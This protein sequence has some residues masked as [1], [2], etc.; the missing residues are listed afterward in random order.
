VSVKRYCLV[1]GSWDAERSGPLRC[2]DRTHPHLS[3]SDVWDFDR[4]GIVE[5]VRHPT[6]KEKGIV[7]LR[8]LISQRGLSCRVGEHLAEALRRRLSWA[9][10]MRADIDMQPASRIP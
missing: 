7:K 1:P 2:E 3:D 10:A 6:R 4:L 9:H 5:Y 8:R